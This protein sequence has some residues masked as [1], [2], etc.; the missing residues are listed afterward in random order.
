MTDPLAN[1]VTVAGAGSISSTLDGIALYGGSKSG[2]PDYHFPWSITNFGRIAAAGPLSTGVLLEG[3]GTID[4]RFGGVISG[5][6][7]GVSVAQLAGAVTNSGSIAAT[8]TGSTGVFLHAGGTVTNLGA[9]DGM[10]AGV[11]ITG[12]TGSVANYGTV[13]GAGSILTY[14]V[15]LSATAGNFLTNS[16]TG[17]IGATDGVG[18]FGTAGPAA[19]VNSGTIENGVI[20][21]HGGNV[22]NGQSGS[23]GGLIGGAFGIDISGGPGAIVNYGAVDFS[24]FG[25]RLNGGGSVRNAQNIA[26][27]ANGYFGVIVYGGGGTV[28]NLGSIVAAGTDGGAA[29]FLG[30]GGNVSNGAA[31]ATTALIKDDAF[32]KDI[33]IEIR[34]AAGTVAN[35][36][37]CQRRLRDLPASRRHGQQRRQRRIGHRPVRR[38]HRLDGRRRRQRRQFRDGQS[39]RRV[40]KPGL[41]QRRRPARGGGIVTNGS[42]A[43]TT[44]TI[45]ADESGSGAAAARG[46]GVDIDAF[47]TLDNYGTV[48][49]TRIGAELFSGGKI[50]SGAGGATAALVS[51][52]NFGVYIGGSA[53]AASVGDQFRH[54]RRDR[55]PAGS[56]SASRTR[57]GT[58]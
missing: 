51:G 33:G 7:Q 1:P 40:D 35:Y 50:A 2:Q 13:R 38:D 20:L 22:S 12:A 6:R 56:A 21:Q 26:T 17:Y 4:N 14:G 49:G 15:V 25:V 16:K 3:G 57:R 42:S 48:K 34:N 39:R 24:R 43:V 5:G 44:A 29:V 58:R 28:A 31:S 30:G 53:T 55:R 54:D 18:V 9:I 32:A 23:A 37:S 8:G 36:G 45:L 52:G 47:G 46:L 41:R 10:E 11:Q 27:G 19:I